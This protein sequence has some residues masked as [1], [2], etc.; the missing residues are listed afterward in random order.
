VVQGGSG[1]PSVLEKMA[2]ERLVIGRRNG[3][4]AT[5]HLVLA[6]GFFIGCAL[7][8]SVAIT[9]LG[10]VLG[11]TGHPGR[12]QVVGCHDV[13]AEQIQK[14]LTSVCTGPLRTPDGHLVNEH[15]VATGDYHLHENET[16]SVRYT[17][18][19][20]IRPTEV[21]Q[22]FQALSASLFTL[23]LATMGLVLVMFAFRRLRPTHPW[24]VPGS[25]PWKRLVRLGFVGALGGALAG[26]LS[27]IIGSF[28]R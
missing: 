4:M 21:G 28:A 19:T 7:L 14:Y 15:G 20:T 10:W 11:T 12:F 5:A 22:T 26:L 24:L 13:I 17:D 16:V 2:Y 6:A 1:E 23:A 27:W 18:A 3:R 9:Q 25:K 8:G